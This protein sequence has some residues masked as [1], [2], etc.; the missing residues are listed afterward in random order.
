MCKVINLSTKRGKIYIADIETFNEIDADLYIYAT[1]YATDIPEGTVHVEQFA[2]S[3][4]L[5]IQKNAWIDKGVFKNRFQ[6][7]VERYIK[8]INQRKETQKALNRLEELIGKGL[9]IVLFDDCYLYEYCH[10]QVF[11][12]VLKE[13]GFRVYSPFDKRYPISIKRY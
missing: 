1:T 6:E 7:F 5:F 2:P 8:E 11:K 4:D 10:L 12:K 3:Y 13:R 9:D